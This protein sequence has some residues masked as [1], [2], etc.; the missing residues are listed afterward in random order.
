MN[1]VCFDLIWKEDK[2]FVRL[3]LECHFFEGSGI[4]Q[5]FSFLGKA[6]WSMVNGQF[7]LLFQDVGFVYLGSG[8]SHDD[9]ESSGSSSQELAEAMPEEAETR[10]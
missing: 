7:P 5:K 10:S 6:K 3:T 1:S 8:H 9:P 4:A 2:F